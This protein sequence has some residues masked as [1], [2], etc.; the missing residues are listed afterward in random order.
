MTHYFV[1]DG[2]LQQPLPKYQS[3]TIK[4]LLG[5][6]TTQLF[7][8]HSQSLCIYYISS[9]SSICLIHSLSSIYF[10]CTIHSTCSLTIYAQFTV[11]AL[12]TLYALFTLHAVL[13]VYGKFT[14]YQ[15][16]G[17][18]SSIF[19]NIWDTFGP[20]VLYVYLFIYVYLCVY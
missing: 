4:F 6:D 1:C 9:P 5:T 16:G 14:L 13:T 12:L 7:H 19:L 2:G 20:Q 8:C 18:N 3:K 17:T 15:G 10:I 11:Y